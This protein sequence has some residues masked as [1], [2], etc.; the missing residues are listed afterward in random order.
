LLLSTT[1][2]L[3]SIS[4][5]CLYQEVLVSVF[6]FKIYLS[7]VAST[8]VVHHCTASQAHRL[9]DVVASL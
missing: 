1:A 7:S 3:S 6:S 5:T 9:D 8:N 2:T 4:T